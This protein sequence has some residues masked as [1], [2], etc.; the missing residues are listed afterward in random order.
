M[1][2][3]PFVP[4]FVPRS[5][6]DSGEQTV[7]GLLSASGERDLRGVDVALRHRRLSMTRSTPRARRQLE[8]LREE[9]RTLARA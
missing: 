5:V 8:E 6:V 1:R 9:L 4:N 2:R 7:L 3:P